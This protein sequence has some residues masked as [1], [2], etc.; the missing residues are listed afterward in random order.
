MTEESEEIRLLREELVWYVDNI[1]IGHAG[2][3]KRRFRS[4][5]KCLANTECKWVLE[6]IGEEALMVSVPQRTPAIAETRTVIA[7]AV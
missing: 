6:G 3:Y 5:V 2:I 1:Q 7:A 4:I